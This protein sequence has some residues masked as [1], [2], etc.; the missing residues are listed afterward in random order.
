MVPV[1]AL[2]GVVEQSSREPLEAERTA[3]R[4]QSHC[5][6]LHR[7]GLHGVA[8]GGFRNGRLLDARRD[9]T[10]WVVRPSGAAMMDRDTVQSE[11]NQAGLRR[12]D[13]PRALDLIRMAREFEDQIEGAD[14]GTLGLSNEIESFINGF[15]A[16][17]SRL[18][19][20]IE[21]DR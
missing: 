9:G 16:L 13:L 21:G 5:V 10:R 17:R 12:R 19:K 7:I 4:P 2:S 6:P 14:D 11:E 18:E 1:R 15:S 8:M 20:S 3:G